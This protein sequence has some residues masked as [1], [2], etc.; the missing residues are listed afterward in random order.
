MTKDINDG[1]MKCIVITTIQPPT[2]CVLKFVEEAGSD[3]KIVVV[4]DK[5]TPAHWELPNVVYLGENE[6]RTYFG[7]LADELPWN[8]YARKNLGYLYAIK[9]GALLLYETDDD[10]YPLDGWRDATTLSSTS[11]TDIVTG[12]HVVNILKHFTPTPIWPRGLPLDLITD[13][14]PLTI[15]PN[16][17]SN[18][19]AVMQWLANGN[20]DVDAIYRLTHAEIDVVFSVRPPVELDSGVFTPC[21]SQNTL[22]SPKAFPLMYLPSF[23]DMRLTD[24]LRGYIAQKCLWAIGARLGYGTATVAQNRNQH[25][26]MK[27]FAGECTTYLS[28]NKI[29]ATLSGLD[30]KGI[31]ASDAMVQCYKSLYK[32]GVVSYEETVLL[33]KWL[34]I[35]SLASN[36]SKP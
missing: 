24:I 13:T 6:Q 15:T 5:K 29:L 30:I 9:R 8:N 17:G 19:I 16:Q 32:I 7:A 23:V 18:N 31:N 22:W 12:P 35:V 21:N 11:P 1:K 10:N 20:P 2:P 27:D 14:S 34:S 26:L 3:W 25:D 4:G 28:S 36:S 33:D